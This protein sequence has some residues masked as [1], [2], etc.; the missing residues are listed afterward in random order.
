M[1]RHHSGVRPPK[2]QISVP[3]G[4]DT[5]TIPLSGR[6]KVRTRHRPP[7]LS[8]ARPPIPLREGQLPSQETTWAGFGIGGGK[9]PVKDYLVNKGA[10]WKDEY[11]MEDGYNIVLLYHDSVATG[12]KFRPYDLKRLFG[13]EAVNDASKLHH[14]N[15]ILP[16]GLVIDKKDF[17]TIPKAYQSILL[18]KGYDAMVK[19]FESDHVKLGDGQWVTNVNWEKLV[20]NDKELG[21]NFTE[22]G[23]KQG[24]D[25]MVAAIDKANK[26]Y[27][28]FL[29]KVKQGDIIPVAGN[30]YITKTEYDKLP[31]GSQQILKEQGFEALAQATTITYDKVPKPKRSWFVLDSE[32][33]RHVK[34]WES[35]GP[36][37]ITQEEMNKIPFLDKDYYQLSEGS[38]GRAG[39]LILSSFIPPLKATLPEYKMGDITALDWG[40]A[41]A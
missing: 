28:E 4:P 25:A 20:A 36:Q 5:G 24:Y 22:I 33:Q 31:S 2:P 8:W 26:P 38:R 10:S 6:I 21:T 3:T 23:K 9:D 14:N 35:V 18:N 39:W 37:T 15:V 7:P 19:K 16:D 1:P 13:V 41:A 29:N 32:Y 40:N 17:E 11:K 30:Q 27:E 34:K 12:A